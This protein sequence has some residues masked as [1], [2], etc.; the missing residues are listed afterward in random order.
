[1]D[2]ATY[3]ACIGDKMRGQKLTREQRKA[4]FCVAAKVCSGKAGSV[5]E[6]QMICALPKAARSPK[7][8]EP[9][10]SCA[11]RMSRVKNSLE[12][13]QLKVKSGEAE[14]VVGLASQTLKDVGICVQEPGTLELFDE[15][16]GMVKELGSRY[17]LSG[18]SKDVKSKIDIL[19]ELV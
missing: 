17:Y 15:A 7:N 13:I 16:M 6:A 12:T 5:E 18:E 19:K 8:N 11:D 1:M 10:L 3:N 2:R 14:D 9:E 4:A